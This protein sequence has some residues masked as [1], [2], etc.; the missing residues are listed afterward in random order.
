M[1]CLKKDLY[2]NGKCKALINEKLE[3]PELKDLR[4]I[5]EKHSGNTDAIYKK[6]LKQKVLIAGVPLLFG[7]GVMGFF[8]AGTS[9]LFTKYRYNKEKQNIK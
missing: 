5:A 2:K 8:I 3:V 1:S 7:I 9:N 6:L 4:K